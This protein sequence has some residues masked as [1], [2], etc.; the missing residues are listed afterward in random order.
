MELIGRRRMNR[1][2][3]IEAIRRAIKPIMA[4]DDIVILEGIRRWSLYG[5]CELTRRIINQPEDR[6]NVNH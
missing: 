5:I 2:P 3:G 6:I 1:I 4:S